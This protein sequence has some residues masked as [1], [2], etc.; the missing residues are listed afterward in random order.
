MTFQPCR[1]ATIKLL[2]YGDVPLCRMPFVGCFLSTI[3]HTICDSL[4]SKLHFFLIGLH[5]DFQ[6]V[7]GGIHRRIGIVETIV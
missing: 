3:S 5:Q 7:V 6:Y 4:Y 1:P 2:P